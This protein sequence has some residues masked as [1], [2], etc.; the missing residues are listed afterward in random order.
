MEQRKGGRGCG[1]AALSAIVGVPCRPAGLASPLSI[2]N[3]EI[4]AVELVGSSPCSVRT[5][6]VTLGRSLP[7]AEPQFLACAMG[8]RVP[9]SQTCGEGARGDHLTQHIP[10]GLQSSGSDALVIFCRPRCPGAAL[11][12]LVSA[13]PPGSAVTMFSCV[14]P[15]EDQ[16]YSALKRACLRRK[17]LFEDPTFPATDD[18]LYYTGTPGPAVRWK[19]PKVSV[20][21][22][23]VP[24]WA[25]PDPP[26]LRGTAGDW[27]GSL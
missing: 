16:N 9:T 19:R 24:R 25:S 18:S 2:R 15:Y 27:Q 5:S 23:L 17:V 22:E 3:E 10:R 7:L 13:S 14:K 20:W 21:S 6:C 4:Q 8:M 11:C 12:C 26:S 1:Q